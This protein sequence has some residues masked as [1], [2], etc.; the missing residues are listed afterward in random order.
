M[1]G[2]FVVRRA[3]FDDP[4]HRLGA[5][6]DVGRPT[7][8]GVS[9][10]PTIHTLR[11]LF[12]EGGTV[13]S[14]EVDEI[15][16]DFEDSLRDEGLLEQVPTGVR[17]TVR[18]SL[19][20]GLVIAHDRP[21]GVQ[22]PRDIVLR[23]SPTTRTVATLTVRRRCRRA[24]DVGTGCGALALLAAAHADEVIATDVNP[25]A[26]WFTELNARL[27]GIENVRCVEGD[28][29]EPVSGES[30][31]LVMGNL[32]FVQSPDTE[33]L[34]R[35]GAR[36]EGRDISETAVVASADALAPDGFATLLV[37]WLVIDG[38]APTAAPLSWV[39]ASGCSGLVLF[40]SVQS[41]RTYAT[42]WAHGPDDDVDEWVEYL[43][44]RGAVSVANG[45]IILHRS[46]PRKV[47]SAKMSVSPSGEGGRQVE[48]VLRAPSLDDEAVRSSRPKI[49]MPYTSTSRVRHDADGRTLRPIEIHLADTAGIAGV[50]QPVVAEVIDRLDG[51]LTVGEA[52]A[53]QRTASP[54][55]VSPEL[56]A[57]VV[58]TVRALVVAGI[59]EPGE[60]T[61]S[62]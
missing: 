4:V 57:A 21:P 27:N 47:R 11:R 34:F 16:P 15:E 32:P 17:A 2:R 56:E 62:A 8:S 46:K 49:V 24:L 28:L 20:R 26:L 35:D 61:P 6:W 12:I 48:R 1:Y 38:E 41:P 37:N 42:N 40:H 36:R 45:A 31:D 19:W 50:V 51:V 60:S 55:T 30:F 44:S 18:I 33:F 13:E 10:A 5:L 59:M 9:P 39:R 14:G 53:A 54:G 22:I 23:P 25:R 43:R 58:S 52:I 3:D 7:R 29:F